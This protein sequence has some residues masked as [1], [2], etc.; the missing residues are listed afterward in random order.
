MMAS[1]VQE[2]LTRILKE[3]SRDTVSSLEETKLNRR[4]IKH[5][6]IIVTLQG[7]SIVTERTRGTTEGETIAA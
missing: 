1:W 5:L 7:G 3:R 2:G 4:E 6:P